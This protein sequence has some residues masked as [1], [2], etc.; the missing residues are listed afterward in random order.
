MAEQLQ[1]LVAATDKTSLVQIEV[2]PGELLDQ[3][4]ILEIK[5]ERIA[6][7]EKRAH[8]RAELAA[9]QRIREQRLPLLDELARLEAELKKV[10]LAI[11]E[12]EDEVRLCERN[13]DF[14]VRFVALARSVYR[15]NDKRATL[16]KQVNAL[17]GSPLDEQK[18]HPAYG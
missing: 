16:K 5:S 14:G 6:V 13:E 9:L 17:L 10:N 4:T 15:N 8:A 3:L 12:V 2:S 1:R 7:V 18:S 11:W